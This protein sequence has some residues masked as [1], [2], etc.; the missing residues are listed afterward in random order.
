MTKSP[1]PPP[2][3]VRR[4]LRLAAIAAGILVLGAGLTLWSIRREDR[5]LR[6]DLLRQTRYVAQTI[7]L[8]RLAVLRGTPEDAQKVEYRRLKEQ[9]MAANQANPDWE[10]IYLMGRR[11]DGTVFFQMD[12]EAYDAPDPSPPGQPYEEAS[13][14]LHR[15]FDT[16]IAATEGPVRDRWGVWVSA[17]I[18]LADPVTGKLATVVGI[19][20]EVSLWRLKTIRAGLVPALATAAL[21]ALLGIAAGQGSRPARRRRWRH[22]E[23]ALAIATGLALT[24]TAVWLVR[25]VEVRHQRESFAWMAQIRTDRVL[26]TFHALRY[27]ELEGLARFI[28][29]SR[30]VTI[31]EF[32]RYAR[33]L[34]R[35]PEVK[36]WAWLPVVEAEHRA[37]FEQEVLGTGWKDF[38]IWEAGPDGQRL[39]AAPRPVLFPIHY[40]ESLE[41]LATYGLAPGRDLGASDAIRAVLDQALATRLVTATDLLPPLPG[42]TGR[43]SQILVF[44]PVLHSLGRKQVTGFAMAAVDPQSLLLDFP[45]ENP[46]EN[47]F[48]SI[49]LLELRTNAAP[50]T[51]ATVVPAPGPGKAVPPPAWVL[52]RPILAFGKTYAISV[53]P[54]ADF[55]AFHTFHLGWIALLAGLA[56]TA[57]GA[58]LVGFFTHRREDIE[59]LVELQS[60]DLAASMRRYDELARHSRTITWEHDA[61][62]VYT[63][64]SESV[65][66]VLGYAPEELIGQKRFYDLHPAEGREAYRARSR[67]IAARREAFLDLVNPVVAKSGETLWMSSTGM[68]VFD[69]AGRLKGYQGTVTDITARKRTEDE[70][71]RLALENKEAAER[72]ATL[73][74]ASNTGAWEYDDRTAHLWASPEYFAMLGRAPADFPLAAD[75]PNIEETWLDLLHPEDRDR[76]LRGFTA[77]IKDPAGMYQQTFRMRHADGRWIWVLARGRVLLDAAGRPTPKVVG[78]HI[79][80]TESKR[81]EQALAES[82]QK[83]RM[84]TE[85]MKDVVW[86]LD[87]DTFRFL[88]VSPSVENLL[89]E[90]AAAVMGRTLDA[91]LVPEQREEMLALVRSRAADLRE[92]RRPP[93]DFFINEVDHLRADGSRLHTEVITRYWLNPRTGQVELHGV[94]RDISARKRAERFWAMGIQTLQILNEPDDLNTLLERLAAMIRTTTGFD[95]VGIRLRVGAQYP[96]V[97]QQGF[98]CQFMEQENDLPVR[99]AQ[100]RPVL[101]DHGRPVLK[102]ACGLVLSGRAADARALATPGGSCWTN[103]AARL[104]PDSGIPH[105]QNHCLGAGYASLALV[106]IRAQ[107]QIVGL[108]QF[109]DRHKDQ[110]SLEIIQILEGIAA[111]VGEAILRKRAEQDYRTLFHEMLEGFSVHEII[112]DGQGQ[113]VDYRFLAVNPAFERMTGLAAADILG[114][115]VREVL[116]ATEPTWIETYGQ[117]ALTGNPAFFRQYAAALGRHFEVAAFRPAP[118]QFACVFSDITDRVRA[119]NELRESRRQYVALLAHLPG[120]AYRCRNDRSWTMEFVSEGCRELTGYAPED[121]V[122]NKVIAFNDLVAPRHRDR[123]W[124]KWQRELR[125]HSRFEDEYEITTRAGET[126]WVWE[127]GEGV[128]DEAGN[129]LGLEGYIADVTERKYAGIER[130]RLMAAIEQSGETV[131]ITD[132]AGRILYVNAAFEKVTG[133]SRAEALGQNPRLLQ[134]G[135]HDAAFY[136]EMWTA[137]RAGRVWEGQIVNRRKNG[138]LFTELASISPVRDASG[139]IVHFVAVKR[140]ITQQLRDQEERDNLQ[141]QLRQ[142][143]KM[144]S[145]GRL[146]GGIAHDFNNMLQ[147]ILGYTEMALEQASPG[148]TLR[149]DLLEIQKTAQRSA[150]LT[151]QL[152]AFARKQPV[153]P[154]LL[155]LNEAIANMSAMLRR[156]IG[157][158]IELAWNPGRDLGLVRIDPGQLDQLVTNLCIN[159]RDA[160]GKAGRIVLETRAATVDRP[161]R[162]LH[163]DIEPG[164]Y[165]VLAVGDNGCGMKEEVLAHIFEPFFTTKT[166]GKGTGLGLAT[167]Y[168]IVQQNHGAVQVLSRPGEGSTFLIYLPRQAGQTEKPTAE[169]DAPDGRGTETIL[170]VEDEEA[171]LHTARRMLEALGYRILATSSA[172]EALRIAERHPGGIDLL[173]TD[174]IMPDLSGPAL[175]KR[176]LERWP[177]L[178]YLYMSG[179]AANLIAQEGVREDGVNF[180]QKPFSRKALA[181]K[182][183]A[184]LDG[185]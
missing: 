60:R 30:E 182:V 162:N 177:S 146:A 27:S 159:A 1:S 127:Q 64:V 149:A 160:I 4:R 140:D 88:Y 21:L 85:N 10:W 86:T 13:P 62:G 87:T 129:L 39:P 98:S 15:V 135:Q 163:G 168:G 136:R 49:E 36:A 92:G 178:K 71:A 113:P 173:L 148:G 73:I 48:L 111:H 32:R 7:P 166:A 96:Y 72:Y 167:V 69:E 184:V 14:L 152:Q 101:D 118:S 171:L 105:P 174:V 25:L 28:E 103:D 164:A 130:E 24:L 58:V 84:L 185:A 40:L 154:K 34:A 51:L 55:L 120:M 172:E 56:I 100:G 180:L 83:Y 139:R 61:E 47:R 18:P 104:F 147:A 12:S 89:G 45:G 33:Y 75:Q 46:E 138:S 155:D 170:I 142:S 133:Y 158:E 179:Y 115:T 124:E 6:E 90:P 31:Q 99:D 82:E 78:T 117:V 110:F 68:P 107:D 183:R 109:N 23:A 79:D 65:A 3:D 114:K 95:A 102:C 29:G 9:L 44:R 94:S 145:I 66:D 132:A 112:C 16:R 165:V 91:L 8:D 35:V 137:L 5:E 123:L 151:R 161:L 22:R 42:A 143:Q 125:D 74:S 175:V 144:E 54:T 80:V 141:S 37:A 116:P 153:A 121:L 169:E 156:L 57:A 67:E 181:Q 81:V 122:G 2:P 53:R 77:Y 59:R 97:V 128:F 52:T 108:M 38:Q 43:R 50:Q 41:S 63:D 134:S 11:N 119:E 70:I 93:A 157:E 150:A 106:P 17:F 76:A 131:L 26:E 126:K 19:D 20:V 176:L